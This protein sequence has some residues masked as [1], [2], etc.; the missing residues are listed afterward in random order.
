MV[1]SHESDSEIDV[2]VYR[3]KKLIIVLTLWVFALVITFLTQQYYLSSRG[4]RI[5]I[6]S[7]SLIGYGLGLNLWSSIDS[8]QRGTKLGNDWKILIMILGIFG[9]F[10]YLLRSRGFGGGVLAILTTI[11]IVLVASVLD[12]VLLAVILAAAGR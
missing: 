4:W 10:G 9:F 2:R 7:L 8:K 5:G 12:K 6:L 11:L 1:D 3:R